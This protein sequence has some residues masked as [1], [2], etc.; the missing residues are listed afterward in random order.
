MV[1]EE[2]EL[3]KAFSAKE[4]FETL[5][6]NLDELKTEE[7]IPD[8]LFNSMKTEYQQSLKQAIETI[9]QVKEKLKGDVRAE[10]INIQ[11]YNQELQNLNTRFKVGEISSENLQ[12][13]EQRIQRRLQRSLDFVEELK[14]LQASQSSVDVGGYVDTKAGG[15]T[16]RVPLGG[17]LTFSSVSVPRMD[18]VVSTIQG[19]SMTD[20]SE[21]RADLNEILESP[22][23]LIGPAGGLVFF[24]SI[25]MPW[26]SMA[27]SFLPGL[28]A[29]SSS[30][31][32]LA[33][34]S[35]G[36]G[37]LV[38]IEVIAAIVAIGSIFLARENARG[39]ILAAIGVTTLVISVLLFPAAI[40]SHIAS[41]SGGLLS[42]ADIASL[43]DIKYCIGYFV[44]IIG[45]LV[46][47]VG[48]VLVLGE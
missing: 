42:S 9:N 31:A 40:N 8:D 23:N 16:G 37:L 4:K 41:L 17:S 1:R 5:L 43:I 47:L 7:S 36:V 27:T 24:I 46:M 12:K 11:R 29:A 28:R 38:L 14:R 22:L 33:S 19:T 30:L 35:S 10:E 6:T 39:I 34:L 2:R 20:F 25:F 21:F 15:M 26:I 13:S 45:S 3:Q 18:N 32:A 44:N 48:G